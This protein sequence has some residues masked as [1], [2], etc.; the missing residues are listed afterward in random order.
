[1]GFGAQVQL[2]GSSDDAIDSFGFSGQVELVDGL[3]LGATYN[4]ALL[5]LDEVTNLIGASDHATAFA[6][7][8]RYDRGPWYAAFSL[9]TEDG[10]EFANV[11]DF[12]V[13]FDGTGAELYVHYDVTDKIRVLGGGNYFS[14]D[15]PDVTLDEDFELKYGVLGL[16]Y[17]FTPDAFAYME[18]K[19]DD[20]V[21]ADGSDGF[22]VITIGGRLDFSFRPDLPG[23]DGDE[24]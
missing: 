13:V 2:R 24:E 5:N 15:D 3:S 10:N 19:L 16:N 23:G 7:G 18:F 12:S 4:R 17:F 9:A 6:G 22:H 1:M 11:A 8:L 20:S 14:P 21:G